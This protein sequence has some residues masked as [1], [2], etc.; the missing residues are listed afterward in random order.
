[1]LGGDLTGLQGRE[2]RACCKEKGRAIGPPSNFKRMRLGRS[3]AH[4]RLHFEEFLKAMLTPFA[5]IS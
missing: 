2:G 4:N 5:A 1:M 3:G